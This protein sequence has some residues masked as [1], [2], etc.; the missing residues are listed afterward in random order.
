M[1]LNTLLAAAAIAAFTAGAAA[2][3]SASPS[4]ADAS[5]GPTN[6]GATATAPSAAENGAPAAATVGAPVAP[7][8]TPADQAYTLKAGD[9]S[10]VSNGPV[11]DTPANRHLYGKPISNA[12]RH[13][14][15][16]GD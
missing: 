3:Q 14:A 6:P 12:G 16:S 7:S 15:A 9:S 8:P 13:T 1:R 5:A 4:G 2:A 11:P 10:V